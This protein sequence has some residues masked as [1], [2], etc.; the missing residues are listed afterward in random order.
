MTTIPT[1][2]IHGVAG[3]PSLELHFSV[4]GQGNGAPILFLS[5][6]P[7]ERATQLAQH[8][9]WQR[10]AAARP[11]ILLDQRGTQFE[12]YPLEAGD[13]WGSR[14]AALDAISAQLSPYLQLKDALTPWQSALDLPVLLAH[15]GVSK[16]DVIAHSYGT[17]LAMAMMKACPDALGRVV[18]LGFE[19]PDQTYKFGSQ[20]LHSLER[21]GALDAVES[22]CAEG[23]IPSFALRWMVCSWLGLQSGVDRLHRFLTDPIGQAERIQRGFLKMLS[24]RSPVFTF[25]DAA[26][27][28]SRALGSEP[29]DE[30]AVFPVPQVADRLGI[31]ALPE[32]FRADPKWHGP[33]LVLTG[34]RDCFTPT[35]NWERAG[36]GFSMATH[37]EIKGAY[38]DTLLLS[39]EVGEMIT[40][41]LLVP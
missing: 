12:P 28:S 4:F 15:L 33:T 16:I 10:L 20:F 22:L 36:K 31:Q 25:C 32:A 1:P 34:E 9:P 2:Q 21:E 24:R 6:G 14:E 40:D 11:I 41:W 8:L 3:L 17:H 29:W 37:H 7:G 35:S 26:S 5:G 19:G 30:A 23:P 13:L 27:G 38:H 39:P 18:M